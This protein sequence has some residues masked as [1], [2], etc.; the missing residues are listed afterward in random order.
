MAT[1]DENPAKR[2]R[3]EEAPPV[4]ITLL[5][6][7]LGSGKTTLLKHVLE[8]KEGLKIG[9]IVNDVAEINIDAALV[10]VRGGGSAA[11]GDTVELQNGCACCSSAEELIQS[12][13]KLMA[14]AE[15]RG[16]PWDHV[17]VEASGVA[18]P[19]EIRDNFLNVATSQPELLA[20][21][22][23]HTMVTVVDASTFLAEF[24]KR[25]KVEQRPD[26][27]T[28]DYT[29]NNRQVVDLMCEQVECADVLVVN[30]TDLSA[31]ARQLELLCETLGSLN[32][33]AK[34]LTSVRGDV[35]L[36]SVLAAAPADGVA[37]LDG[38]GEHRR[39]VKDHNHDH[40]HHEHGH[41]GH[42]AAAPSAAEHE[43]GHAPPAAEHGH[44]PDCRRVDDHG[45]RRRPGH[46]HGHAHGAGGRRV[47]AE[48]VRS[49]SPPTATSAALP[50]K[51][52][53]DVPRPP[54]PARRRPRDP[55]RRRARARLPPH[56]PPTT[57]TNQVCARPA[58]TAL[59]EAL[60]DAAAAPAAAAAACRRRRRPPPPT[61]RRRR[62]RRGARR[63]GGPDGAA[64]AGAA[65]GN[66][67]GAARPDAPRSPDARADPLEGFLWLSNS[68]SQ[69]FYWALA[70]KPELKQYG[71]WWASVAEEEWPLDEKERREIRK[72]FDA[73]AD[74]LGDRRQEVVFIGVRM[75][76]AAITALLDAC[77]LT[78][79]EMDSYKQHW[80]RGD[81]A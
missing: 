27:G 33:A 49:A 53:R 38:E 24:E 74:G 81:D 63:R 51:R 16:V 19:R 15:T 65:G 80:N 8:N 12:V 5:C 64:A 14:L 46:A 2:A 35:S 45:P 56:P 28:D 41:G 47:G 66:P 67:I 44:A 21:A 3:T 18:E 54:R 40:G 37:S 9:M 32:P 6:G 34:V 76:K 23:L 58:A 20:G 7:F 71:M 69:I 22:R 26:L 50:P 42:A 79:T 13:E 62:R 55:R 30:K 4:P 17:V 70:G 61:A 60:A 52:L 36:A 11:A 43:H 29:D 25:N 31:S 10:A 72:D 77:L 75:D 59:T 78:D 57:T 73:S 48:A 39:M 1:D 68:H